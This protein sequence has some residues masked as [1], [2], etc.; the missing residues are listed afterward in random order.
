MGRLSGGLR[1][2]QAAQPCLQL[3]ERELLGS[4][5]YTEARLLSG[6]TASTSGSSY[7]SL[8]GRVSASLRYDTVNYCITCSRVS[9]ACAGAQKQ[10]VCK[11]RRQY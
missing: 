8:A 6:L 11:P 2:L 5:R 4:C 7:R 1:L 3:A 9:C 10:Y